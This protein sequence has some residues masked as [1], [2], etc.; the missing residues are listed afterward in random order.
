MSIFKKKNMNTD[1]D[2]RMCLAAQIVLQ[3]VLLQHRH[4][5]VSFHW[6]SLL[7]CQELFHPISGQSQSRCRKLYMTNDQPLT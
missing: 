5:P 4:P 7:L 3:L 2:E 6:R 1:N